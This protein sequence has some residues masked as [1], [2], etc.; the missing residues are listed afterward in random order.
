MLQYKVSD[1]D[2]TGEF[3]SLLARGIG[4]LKKGGV[5]DNLMAARLVLNDWNS[6]KIK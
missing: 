2:G 1:F 4:K 3:L 5:P 6:G